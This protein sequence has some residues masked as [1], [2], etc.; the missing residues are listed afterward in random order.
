MRRNKENMLKAVED[1]KNLSKAL[2]YEK[3]KI[4][5]R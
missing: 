5:Y 1:K 2:R 4:S 3:I